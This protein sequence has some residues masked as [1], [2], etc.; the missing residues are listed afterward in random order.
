MC[1][2]WKL[3]QCQLLRM[4]QRQLQNMH[5]CHRL[6]LQLTHR[7]HLH[8]HHLH[9][10]PSLLFLV[11]QLQLLSSRYNSQT[12]LVPFYVQMFKRV[13]WNFHNSV[14]N[15]FWRLCICNGNLPNQCL[16]HFLY[17][18]LQCR[19]LNQDFCRTRWQHKAQLW[20]WA[21]LWPSFCKNLESASSSLY[22]DI[23]DHILQCSIWKVPIHFLRLH[24]APHPTMKF[25]WN[26]KL[27][28]LF[29][30]QFL[31]HSWKS[32]HRPAC[33]PACICTW[34]WPSWNVD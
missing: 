33:L 13:A 18:M 12:S 2:I 1:W 26:Q 15:V 28:V 32:L 6:M 34:W 14:W 30:Y 21:S 20:H 17:P 5:Q 29:V 8:Q 23:F 9:F 10:H 3:L 16:M 25:M 22:F 11:A 31:N 7:L 24:R 27:T 19:V 4:H